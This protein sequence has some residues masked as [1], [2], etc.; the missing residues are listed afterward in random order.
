MHDSLE[1]SLPGPRSPQGRLCCRQRG[2]SC[3]A[4]MDDVVSWPPVSPQTLMDIVTGALRIPEN[5]SAPVSPSL[6]L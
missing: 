2:W 4:G 1:L 5:F 6:P 3:D